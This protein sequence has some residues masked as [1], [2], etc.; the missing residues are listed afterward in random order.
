MKSWRKI[1]LVASFLAM[2]GLYFNEKVLF[3]AKHQ[4]SLISDAALFCNSYKQISAFQQGDLLLLGASRMQANFDLNRFHRQFPNRKIAMLAQSGKGTSY[5]VFRDLVENTSFNGIVL[6]DEN[7][8]TLV[9]Q[10]YD[11]QQFIDYCYTNFSFNQWLNRQ[12]ATALQG[13][14]ALLNPQSSSLRL[15]SNIL[16]RRE[17][18]EP[19]YTTTLLDR[20]QLIDYAR[21]KPIL[22]QQ[23]YQNRIK[24][25][26]Q[27]VASFPIPEAWL[28][29]TQH[30][31]LLV[32]KFE[33]RGGQVV[34]VRMPVAEARWAIEGEYMPVK[35][36]WNSFIKQLNVPSI[37]FAEHPSLSSFEF[38]DTS[39]LDMRDK[40][41]FTDALLVQ[42]EQILTP[43]S[44]NEIQ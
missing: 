39:H 34:F 9:S 21:A 14:F 13:Q 8:Q 38:P 10:T 23:L 27:T 36:Y 33:A 11:Q 6:I 22:L 16:I 42:V 5:P 40:E 17:L 24:G 37:H 15:W 4:P 25:V 12:I 30:W 2:G 1:W 26:Q 18:P 31:Q 20:Q 7:E 29:K 35:L 43:K 28:A 3:S 32:K 41:R 19:F 44:P